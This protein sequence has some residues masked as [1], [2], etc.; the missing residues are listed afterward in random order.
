MVG[1]WL[2]GRAD[3]TVTPPPKSAGAEQRDENDANDDHPDGPANRQ[4]CNQEKNDQQNDGADYEDVSET[5]E[6]NIWTLDNSRA[7][8]FWPLMMVLNGNYDN[9]FAAILVDDT[10]GESIN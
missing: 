1:P 10:V 9:D 7:P 3:Q 5:H 6:S 2:G 4:L 8:T